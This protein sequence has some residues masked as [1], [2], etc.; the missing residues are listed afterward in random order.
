L[1]LAAALERLSPGQDVLEL[2]NLLMVPARMGDVADWTGEPELPLRPAAGGRRFGRAVVG[3]S[4][5]VN[6]QRLTLDPDLTDVA[7]NILNRLGAGH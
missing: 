5:E 2:G 6:G 1:L 7:R 3:T 4:A